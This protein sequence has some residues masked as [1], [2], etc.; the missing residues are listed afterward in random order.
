ML[1]TRL[2]V[3]ALA[4]LGLLALVVPGCDELITEVNEITIAGHP[5][6]EFGIG[7]TGADSGCVPFEVQFLDQSVG[8]ITGWTWSFGD[9]TSS[10][11]TNPVHVYDSAGVYEVALTVENEPTDGQDTEV[12]KRYIVAGTTFSEF[13]S[14]TNQ[15]CVGG[16][17]TFQPLQYGGVTSWSWDF[18][19][20]AVDNS[21]DSTPSHVYDSIGVYSV[22][23]T[24]QGECGE[25]VE[26]N[27]DMITITACPTVVIYADTP[28]AGCRPFE[29][30]FYDSSTYDTSEIA[31]TEWEWDF[32][33]NRKSFEQ[34]PLHEYVSNGT[35]TVTLTVNST[36]GSATDSVVDMITVSDSVIADFVTISPDTGCYTGFQDFAVAF[37]DSSEGDVLSWLW[38]FGDGDSSTVQHPIHVYDSAGLYSVT[39]EVSGSCGTDALTK[40]DLVALSTPLDPGSVVYTISPDT[41]TLEPINDT[42]LA[43]VIFQESTPGVLYREWD[44]GYSVPKSDAAFTEHDYGAAG[45]YEITLTLGNGCGEIQIIDTVIILPEPQ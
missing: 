7:G 11:D 37:S 23:L 9:G 26:T 19:D 35:Y 21:N 41:A 17:I 36:G 42:A 3:G 8:P 6:A 5:Q 4:L 27:T 18:G 34:N 43:T 44:F 38:R 30:Q 20:G 39:L 12:K 31:L 22:T 33:D 15:A 10:N 1:R 40:S 16:E 25:K 32:G 24:V 29:V 28:H 13:V 2:I 45:T 14:D